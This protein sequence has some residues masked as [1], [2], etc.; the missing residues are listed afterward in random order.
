[1]GSRNEVSNSYYNAH[2]VV[3]KGDARHNGP[4]LDDIRAKQEDSYRRQRQN[5]LSREEK[6]NADEPTESTDSQEAT[7]ESKEE[8]V[9]KVN[10]EQL[11]DFND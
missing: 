11:G 6:K 5:Q 3:E 7:P 10:E 1:M 2:E 9:S 8:E 4:Y